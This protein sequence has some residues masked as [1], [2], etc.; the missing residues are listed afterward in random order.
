MR[1]WSCMIGE[2]PNEALPDGSDAPMR[3]A[4]RR[5]YIELTGHHDVFLFSGWGDQLDESHRAVVEN[6][7]P[8]P[9]K[10]R[11]EIIDRLGP[12]EGFISNLGA[13][14][15]ALPESD[16]D[17]AADMGTDVVSAVA[18]MAETLRFVGSAGD[19]RAAVAVLHRLGYRVSQAIDESAAERRAA[20]ASR[21]ES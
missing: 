4:V 2:V 6:R 14:V 8:D 7:E 13:D 19:A 5:A 3:Q 11:D 20:F 17:P 21:P 12:V 1:M 9:Y 16:D 18:A 10:I 15:A